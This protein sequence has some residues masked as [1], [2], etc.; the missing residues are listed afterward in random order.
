MLK[1][2]WYEYY[3]KGSLTLTQRLHEVILH[4]MMQS[5]A[6]PTD[7]Q[8]HAALLDC[9]HPLVCAYNMDLFPLKTDGAAD[10]NTFPVR[11]QSKARCWLAAPSP[12]EPATHRLWLIEIPLTR[13][14]IILS[15]AKLLMR[16]IHQWYLQGTRSGYQIS[17]AS[18]A[19]V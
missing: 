15:L 7:P 9:L 19:V 18:A 13:S 10:T 16:Y 12:S 1:E 8:K 5:G 6:K 2:S 3:G 14:P 11:C 17:H 4:W